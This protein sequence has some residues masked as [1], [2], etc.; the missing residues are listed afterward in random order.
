MATLRLFF[1]SARNANKRQQRDGG[2]GEAA[3]EAVGGAG[4]DLDDDGG[5]GDDLDEDGD[6]TDD[7]SSEDSQS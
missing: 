7:A 4:D 6:A 5:A 3:A 1:A 2:D